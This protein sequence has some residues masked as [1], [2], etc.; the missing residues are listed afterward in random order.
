MANA[1]P[2]M[3][4]DFPRWHSNVSVGADIERKNARWTAVHALA[5]S[6][7]RHMVEAL[8]RLAFNTT[9]QAPSDPCLAKIHEAFQN[10]DDTFDP[11]NAGRELKVYAGACLQLLFEDE[12]DV[13]AAAALSVTTAAFV[14][15]RI[16]DLP[17][18]LVALAE[19]A[20]SK[21]ADA[22]RARPTLAIC[23]E[24]P[25][26]D[27]DTAIE[28]V[29]TEFNG[30]SV[31]QALTTTAQSFKAALTGLMTSQAK[32]M[33]AVDRFIH[34]QD[35]ELQMLSWL[36]GGWSFD[37]DRA[38]SG[39]VSESQPLLFAKELADS[40]T[41]LPGPRSIKALLVRAGLKERKKLTIAQ[42]INAMEE[43]WLSD[44]ANENS[45][46]VTTPLHFAIRRQMET[47]GG[48]AWIQNWAAV[49]GCDG[50]RPISSVTLAVQFYRER[51]LFLFE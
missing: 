33:A 21:I 19:A 5:K 7:D 23:G 6:A 20:I 31:A 48:D 37:L 40:T 30:D 51:L 9:R 41:L 24:A 47:S 15:A 27:I 46:S 18:D 3:H 25:K 50:D 1:T 16:P 22:N 8:V 4:K 26:F 34:V 32:A 11:R 44:L 12:F 49:V 45:S 43:N 38:F 13:G 2:A 14:G 39:I 28:K 29:Q 42:A 36:T 17:L 35:E 10:A